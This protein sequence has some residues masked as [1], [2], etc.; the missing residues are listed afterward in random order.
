MNILV[1]QCGGG[2]GHCSANR[3]ISLHAFVRVDRTRSFILRYSKA[4]FGILGQPLL[5]LVIM[6]HI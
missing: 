4:L 2:E 3:Y 6:H 1:G 5:S